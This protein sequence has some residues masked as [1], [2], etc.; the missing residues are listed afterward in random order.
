MVITDRV[1][2][3]LQVRKPMIK[4]VSKLRSSGFKSCL[5]SIISVLPPQPKVI[6]KSSRAF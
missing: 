2:P 5:P 6:G 4:K 3:L 1:F